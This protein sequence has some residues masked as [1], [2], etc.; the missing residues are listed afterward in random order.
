MKTFEQFDLVEFEVG[1]LKGKGQICGKAIT[2]Q[3][4]IGTAW[5]VH[6]LESNIDSAMYPYS[7]I[8]CPEVNLKK[9]NFI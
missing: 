5:I 1:T 3:P 2:E 7:H 6:V 9:K 4:V 8:V